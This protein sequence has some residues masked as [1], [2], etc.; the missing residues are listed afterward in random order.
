M[1]FNNPGIGYF[2]PISS[3]T[4][5]LGPNDPELGT[6]IT[7]NGEDYVLAYNVGS[8]TAGMNKA[9]IL[10]ASTGYSFTVS[11]LTHAGYAFGVVKHADIATGYYGWVLVRGYAD[12]K[13]GMVSTAFA[14][15][16]VFELAADGGIAKANSLLATGAASVNFG[17]VQSAGASGGTGASLTYC[18]IKG[19]G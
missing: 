1:G 2:L 12:I 6:K 19:I 5:S 11:S 9:V 8:S 7:K 16:D 18:Y 10:S 3:T 13:N 15:G 4:N 14:A 17:V